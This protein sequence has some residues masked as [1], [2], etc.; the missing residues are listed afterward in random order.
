M[1]LCGNHLYLPCRLV[2]TMTPSPE[3]GEEQRSDAPSSLLSSDY[4]FSP[5]KSDHS[6]R[7]PSGPHQRGGVQA[8]LLFMKPTGDGFRFPLASLL[9]H[10]VQPG[11]MRTSP[12]VS[13]SPGKL[14]VIQITQTLIPSIG[15][16]LTLKPSPQVCYTWLSS[17]LREK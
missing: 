5:V 2:A 13:S 11:I 6:P 4:T 17:K 14:S 10:A 12:S 1:E 16:L 3:T 15:F 7:H 8:F 9:S